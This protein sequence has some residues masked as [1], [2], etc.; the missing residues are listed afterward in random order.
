VFVAE[1]LGL[2]ERLDAFKDEDSAVSDALGYAD[3]TTGPTGDRMDIHDRMADMLE[4]HGPDSA[5][6]RVHPLRKRHLLAAADRVEA[7][8]A[9]LA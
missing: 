5:N 1:E 7:R 6:A 9:T 4:R 2:R 3:Q 8:L